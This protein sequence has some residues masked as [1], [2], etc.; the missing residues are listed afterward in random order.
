M[1]TPTQRL[2]RL[3]AQGRLGDAAI[4]Q[5]T[6]FAL[7]TVK[8]W[9]RS[10]GAL[11]FPPAQL[12]GLSDR[13][14]QELIT[15][16]RFKHVRRFEV[17]DFELA[18]REKKGRKVNYSI[19]F[20]EYC[21]SA[22]SADA[23]MSRSTFY[24][25]KA[26]VEGKK[27]TELRFVYEPGEMIQ[28]D[29]IGI[30]LK[31]LPKVVGPDGKVQRYD[32]ACGISA[33]SRKM[34]VEATADQTRAEF[35]ATASRMLRFFGG[36]PVLMTT[37]NFPAVIRQPRRGSNEEVATIAYQAFADH[38]GYGIIATRVRKPRDKGLVE[39]AVRIAQEYIMA[40]IRNRVFFSLAELNAAI[41]Q[42]LSKLNAR[43]MRDHGNQSRDD[44]FEGDRKGF[45]E[46]PPTDY[47]DG[48]W[49]LRL[50]AGRDYRIR[51]L[52]SQYSVPNQY[53]G[54]HFDAK[55]T[56]SSMHIYRNGLLS[57]RSNALR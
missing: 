36:V 5:Q 12:D 51:V 4:R 46:L 47:E 25:L 39:G 52:G 22:A 8:N 43:P 17:P 7:N 50:R 38:Y 40:R 23:L 32:V 14:L 29:Y 21:G 41:A 37:D 31:R 9:R 16:G 30:K 18:I 34:F 55:V 44:L 57:G 42:L 49:V 26:E 35:F 20:D 48:D 27:N 11:T 1:I 45:S 24:R 2:V 54:E 56:H 53:V 3:I 19:S 13:E 6:G 28:F 33:C 15:P 10:I